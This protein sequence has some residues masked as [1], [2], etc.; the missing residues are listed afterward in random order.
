MAL[1]Q[2]LKANGDKNGKLQRQIQRAYLLK[3]LKYDKNNYDIFSEVEPSECK[4]IDKNA[5]LFI[6]KKNDQSKIVAWICVQQNLYLACKKLKQNHNQK[7][8]DDCWIYI[9]PTDYNKEK[10]ALD[11]CD[12]VLHYSGE[13]DISN[14]LSEI[15]L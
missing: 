4:D 2:I 3:H 13:I 6:K 1:I 15:E 7:W 14:L 9:K 10:F 5:G 8:R 11:Y 12:N